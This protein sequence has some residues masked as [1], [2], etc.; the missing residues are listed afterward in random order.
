MD[1]M[2]QAFAYYDWDETAGR[3]VYTPGVVRP[4]YFNNDTTF[5][6]GF[7][8]PDDQWDNYWRHGATACSAGMRP[9]AAVRS[10]LGGA[11]GRG[12]ARCGGVPQRPDAD[13][14]ATGRR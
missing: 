4:K 5:A 3:I 7:A 11:R 10:R 1:P 13:D 14:G 2:A 6:P 12:L 8:T 9:L